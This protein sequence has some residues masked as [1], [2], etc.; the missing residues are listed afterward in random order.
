MQERQDARQKTEWLDKKLEK[1]M[2]RLENEPL[3][4]SVFRGGEGIEQEDEREC[5]FKEAPNH[6]LSSKELAKYRSREIKQ[7]YVRAVDKNGKTHDFRLRWTLQYEADGPS[8]MI[9]I[10]YKSDIPSEEALGRKERQ[11]YFRLDDPRA[12]DWYRLWGQS[13][14]GWNDV[15]KTRY[16]IPYTATNKSEPRIHY[17]VFHDELEGLRRFEVEFD[18]DSD[19][20]FFKLARKRDPSLNFLGDDVTKDKRYGGKRLARYGIPKEN[21]E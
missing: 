13:T 5:R 21:K 16:F 18:N 11:L 17:D 19:A 1:K 14:E 4:L 10:D 6:K 3:L 15:R 2:V 8:I 7:T 20:K 9:G 12:K